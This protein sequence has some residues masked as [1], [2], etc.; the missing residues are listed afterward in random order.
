MAAKTKPWRPD[1]AGRHGTA[2]GAV[3]LCL[4]TVSIATMEHVFF[5]APWW[6]ASVLVGAGVLGTLARVVFRS[7]ETAP[8]TVVYQL[9]C[10]VGV[11][12]WSAW[13]LT[14]DTWTKESFGVGILILASGT[15]VAGILASLGGEDK[16][17]VAKPA[18]MDLD[19]TSQRARNVLGTQYEEIIH[20]LAGNRKEDPPL[21]SVEGIEQWGRGGGHTVEGLF[22]SG[23]FGIV[24]LQRLA[25]RIALDLG[26]DEGCG[27]EVKELAGGS[28]KIWLMDVT[29]RNA[30]AEGCPFPM[31]A[32][33]YS[34][35]GMIPVGV[36][37][38]GEPIGPT[39]RQ[40]NFAIQGMPG[41]GKTGGLQATVA[42]LALTADEIS[43]G[44]DATGADLIEPFLRAFRDG[45][46]SLPVFAQ[47]AD[48]YDEGAEQLRGLMRMGHARKMGYGYLKAQYNV[49]LLPMGAVVRAGDLDPGARKFYPEGAPDRLLSQIMWIG[50]ETTELLRARNPV[51]QEM[52]DLIAKAMQESRGSGIRFIVP[53]LGGDDQY[54]G[55]KYQKLIHTV[56]ALRMDN[57]AEYKHALGTQYTV[58]PKDVSVVGTGLWRDNPGASLERFRFYGEMTPEVV[59][60]IAIRADRLGTLPDLDFISELAANGYLPD[61]SPWPE[62]QIMQK[63]DTGWWDRRWEKL[64]RGKGAPAQAA[65]ASRP[66]P[67]PRGGTMTM[68]EIRSRVAEVNEAT[69]ARIAEMEERRERIMEIE[70]H[71]A[72]QI[73]ESADWSQLTGWL[74]EIPEGPHWHDVVMQRIAE[75]GPEG[76][77]TGIL[78]ALTGMHRGTVSAFL[79][80]QCEAGEVR[81]LRE[82]WYAL[83]GDAA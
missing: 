58:D 12:V 34:I 64:T 55:Q 35:N 26:L 46:A 49:A 62:G 82:G 50:D 14:R 40:K 45:R 74:P 61:G 68:D 3:N 13:M 17:E 53:P 77:K 15:L 60:A 44:F 9:L 79:Q 39:L 51:H 7:R 67:A 19:A 52:A 18:E 37:P 23:K 25:P 57:M 11:G 24:E 22:V 43:L 71:A 63:G 8:A 6:W 65:P 75:A 29:K 33:P 42:A 47:Y 73:L 41:S 70:E 10:W 32:G 20:R 2:W 54:I 78:V 30:L 81:R 16:P 27:V 21:V 76:V 83:P 56:T 4:T 66:A 38:N 59:E 1:F 31:D 48:S 36:K 72:E 80:A 28:R 5:A 69:E